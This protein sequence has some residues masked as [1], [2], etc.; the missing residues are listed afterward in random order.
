MA[1]RLHLGTEGLRRDDDSEVSLLGRAAGHG[2][3]MGVQARIIVDFEE[4]RLESVGNLRVV[5]VS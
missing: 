5:L 3:V 4:G 1:G 2:L